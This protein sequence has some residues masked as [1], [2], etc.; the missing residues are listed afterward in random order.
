LTINDA[1]VRFR[2]FKGEWLLPDAKGVLKSQKLQTKLAE[3]Q[4][5]L[6]AI[7]G[8]VPQ[9]HHVIAPQSPD[10]KTPF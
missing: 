7:I 4:A 8:R 9:Q 3:V 1:A 5:Q 6:V 2:K 10:L